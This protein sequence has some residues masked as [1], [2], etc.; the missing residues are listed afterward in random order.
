MYPEYMM[1]SIKK[2]EE[3]RPRRLEKSKKYGKEVFPH[4]T[5]KEREEILSKFHPDYKEGARK[6][7]RV[8]PNKGE[9]LT[10]EISDLLESYSRIN[11]K[12]FNLDK[13]D[14]ETDV[15]VIGAG[16]AGMASALVA[17]KNGSNVLI[18][19]KL[20]LGDSNS[21]MAEGGIQ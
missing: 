11:P 8:G 20:R 6:E 16:S 10:T 17:A 21:M 7:V 2:V 18:V 9:I 15:L 1:E 3:T 13:I 4:M 19:T 12:D 14:Y 5:D